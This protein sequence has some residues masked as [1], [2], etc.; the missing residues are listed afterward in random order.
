[1]LSWTIL[2]AK[3]IS[4]ICTSKYLILKTCPEGSNLLLFNWTVRIDDSKQDH[5][6]QEV[7]VGQRKED[8]SS[9]GD[10]Y[11]NCG[12]VTKS[13]GQFLKYVVSRNTEVDFPSEDVPEVDL[14]LSRDAFQIMLNAQKKININ[15]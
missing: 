13:F 10:Y 6:I 14:S 8:L 15:T 4:F 12:E 11:L 1:M 9:V 2:S 7:R 5:Q 3:H